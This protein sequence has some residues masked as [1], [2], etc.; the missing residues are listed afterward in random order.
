MKNRSISAVSGRTGEMPGASAASEYMKKFTGDNREKLFQA[1]AS[2][3]RP[4]T[5]RRILNLYLLVGE[6]EGRNLG[7]CGA[8]L[9]LGCS[10]SAARNYI[11]ELLDAGV[12][13]SH[14]LRAPAGDI[15]R[16][17]YHLAADRRV[18]REF[19]AALT[20]WHKDGAGKHRVLPLGECDHGGLHDVADSLNPVTAQ[21]T[22]DPLVSALFGAPRL[23]K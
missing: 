9:F 14:P 19:L 22:R 1:T 12:I 7:C 17:Q 11:Y 4:S 23:D 10:V 20:Q 21:T 18:V 2:L 3:L 13:V 8:S 15:D 5:A 6:F 16:T